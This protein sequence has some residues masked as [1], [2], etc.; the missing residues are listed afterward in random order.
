MCRA[1]RAASRVWIE[2]TGHAIHTAILPPQSS[3][4]RCTEMGRTPRA[5]CRIGSSQNMA[6]CQ[7]HEDKSRETRRLKYVDRALTPRNSGLRI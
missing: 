1:S 2:A 6:F 5:A 7:H 4:E 3:I